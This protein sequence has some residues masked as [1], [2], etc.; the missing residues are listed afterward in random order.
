M[1]SGKLLAQKENAYNTL[2]SSVSCNIASDTYIQDIAI[3]FLILDILHLV[4]SR[5]GTKN[6]DLDILDLDIFGY[7]SLTSSAIFITY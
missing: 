5:F 4:F 3:M 1:C 7:F 6:F 2:T